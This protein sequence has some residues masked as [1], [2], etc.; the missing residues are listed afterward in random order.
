MSTTHKK[1]KVPSFHRIIIVL[2]LSFLWLV[3]NLFFIY[4][5]EDRFFTL[6]SR[7]RQGFATNKNLDLFKGRIISGTVVATENNLG[8]ISIFFNSH[9]RV[10]HDIV[11]FR[12]KEEGSSSWFYEADYNTAAFFGLSQYPLGFPLITD[13]EGK[14]Y[15]FELVSLAGTKNNHVTVERNPPI[16][17]KYV[18]YRASVLDNSHDLSLFS[19]KKIVNLI[20]DKDVVYAFLVN[21]LP[22]IFYIFITYVDSR[23]NLKKFIKSSIYAY[24]ADGF[25]TVATHI[26]PALH[27]QVDLKKKQLEKKNYEMLLPLLICAL[28]LWD[29]FFIT[30]IIGIIV[31]I[32]SI[33]WIFISNTMEFSYKV[34]LF[35]VTILLF[36]LPFSLLFEM[37]IVPEKLGLWIYMMLIMMLIIYLRLPLKK[38]VERI[39]ILRHKT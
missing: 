12:I 10:V 33:M 39:S 7:H 32:I 35:F 5:Y 16:E 11:R 31:I 26:S 38:I 8:I 28:I 20:Q 27:D 1:Q 18:F 23:V 14:K 21:M 13:S 2:L 34:S 3:M 22:L 19:E 25:L 36:M 37:V 30:K 6:V 24:L 15:Y 29:I 9:T 4:N 17:S